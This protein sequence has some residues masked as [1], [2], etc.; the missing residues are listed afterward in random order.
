LARPGP[1]EGAGGDADP[2]PWRGGRT[3]GVTGGRVVGQPV[4]RGVS[5]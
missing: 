1:G 3:P 5:A 4:R 2:A